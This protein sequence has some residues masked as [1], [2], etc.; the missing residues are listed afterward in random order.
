MQKVETP[1]E[2]TFQG[3]LSNKINE[4]M[5]DDLLNLEK[6]LRYHLATNQIVRCQNK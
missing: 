4:L 6:V 3:I 5:Q 2:S 1:N